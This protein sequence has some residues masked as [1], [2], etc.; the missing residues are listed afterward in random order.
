MSIHVLSRKANAK[1]SNHSRGNLGFSLNGIN[2]G[3]QGRVG[4]SSMM[5][6]T[7]GPK[8]RTIDFNPS[9]VQNNNCCTTSQTINTS[10]KNTRGMIANRNRFKFQDGNN[11]NNSNRTIRQRVYNQ[12]V[13]PDDAHGD[14]GDQSNFIERKKYFILNCNKPLDSNGLN[15]G[16]EHISNCANNSTNVCSRRNG[17]ARIGGKHV[18]KTVY[19][20]KVG[21]GASGDGNAGGVMTSHEHT[22]NQI[23]KRSNIFALREQKTFPFRVNRNAACAVTYDQADDA[24]NTHYYTTGFEN[25][26]R[27]GCS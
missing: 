2:R 7:G 5:S 1:Y 6:R 23:Y 11:V 22:L 12:W 16:V 8:A 3:H 18:P 17:G 19:A 4:Q 24:L 9:G 26:T 10:V 21:D 20:K 13:Q 14:N 25:N 27:P 15:N